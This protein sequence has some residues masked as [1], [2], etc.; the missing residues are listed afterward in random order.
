MKIILFT[1]SLGAGGAQRQLV[2][3]AVM[4]KNI[5]HEVKV[6]TYHNIDFYK[7]YLDENH[8]KNELIQNADDPKKRIFS[9]FRY[10]KKES[11]N[12]VIAYQETPSLIACLCKIL[13]CKYKLIVSER[14]TTQY[15]GLKEKVRFFLYRWANDIVP[16]SY[17]Q[18]KFLLSHYTWMKN[19][20]TTISN[21][22]DL[23]KFSFS[24]KIKSGIP[25][26]VVAATIWHSKNTKGLIKAVKI[27]AE[28]QMVFKI[29]WYGIINDY[30]EY[31]EECLELIRLYKLQDYIEL[32]PKTKQIHEKYAECDFFCLPSFYEGTPNVIC[33]AMACGRPILCSNV[34]DNS[35]YVKEDSNGFLFNPNNPID[36]AS[37]IQKALD[38]N[39]ME[40]QKMCKCSRER[41][42]SMLSENLFLSKYIK[43]LK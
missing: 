38:L 31:L 10:L 26:I 24:N 9:V 30:K 18:E 41:A 22:V 8:V 13:G 12:Y 20:V 11:P 5:K 1:D 2:G 42:N 6:C 25:I 33:E 4:L 15:I 21:F 40:Y 36:I 32:L 23:D 7:S 19:K 39:D 28:K 29:K 3:L 35:I 17:S 43:I 34:C 16:N 37:K 27:L 14:N